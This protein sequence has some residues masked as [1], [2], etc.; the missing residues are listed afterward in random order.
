M[1]NGENDGGY[2]D[3]HEGN[4]HTEHQVTCVTCQVHV[5]D[6]HAV[7]LTTVETWNG[8]VIDTFLVEMNK[9]YLSNS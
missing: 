3:D 2:E 1:E 6:R 7:V 4:G 5:G 8:R 9:W